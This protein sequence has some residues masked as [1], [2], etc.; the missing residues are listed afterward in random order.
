MFSLCLYSLP[1]DIKVPRRALWEGI[2]KERI[3]PETPQLDPPPPRDHR[4]RKFFMFPASFPFK[5]Q[6]RT[7]T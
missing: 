3:L 7:K 1:R 5:I 2:K 4:P 6:E